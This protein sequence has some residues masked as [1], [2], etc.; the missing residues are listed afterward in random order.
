MLPYSSLYTSF[1]DIHRHPRLLRTAI[2]S[3]ETIPL[4]SPQHPPLERSQSDIS[5]SLKQIIT[6]KKFCLIDIPLNSTVQLIDPRLK[7]LKQS[8]NIYYLESKALKNAVQQQKRLNHYYD[9]KNGSTPKTHYALI[10]FHIQS[11][12]SKT[13]FNMNHSSLYISVMD[14]FHF[15]LKKSPNQ[16]YIDLE[17]DENKL[18]HEQMKISDQ[19]IHH[20]RKL[21]SQEIR[22]HLR[23]KRERKLEEQ[24]KND[25][26]NSKIYIN[27]GRKLL[28]EHQEITPST[29]NQISLEL[30]DFFSYEYR[31]ENR[32][33]VKRIL[34]ELIGV[35]VEKYGLEQK[36]VISNHIHNRINQ[37]RISKDYFKL[38]RSTICLSA[39]MKALLVS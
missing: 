35:F 9:P 25:L 27:N 39:N 8:Q 13:S 30:L 37:G 14:C 5:S 1:S 23:E 29:N 10:P 7:T 24:R 31:N 28:K 32:P 22:L 2:S 34:A 17:E 3:A 6:E 15:G 4:P 21:N 11:T 20:E 38:I 18:A 19:L 26:L 16:L 36:D 12:S 33:H